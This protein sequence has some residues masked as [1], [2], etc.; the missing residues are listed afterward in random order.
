MRYGLVDWLGSRLDLRKLLVPLG[1]PGGKFAVFL[2]QFKP[3]TADVL[4]TKVVLDKRPS[5]E[6]N[7]DHKM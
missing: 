1:F 7:N 5:P 6:T 2:E 4:H 3:V